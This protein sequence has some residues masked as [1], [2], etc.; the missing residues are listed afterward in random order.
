LYSYHD[1]SVLF[2]FKKIVP[3]G[4]DLLHIEHFTFTDTDN[5]PIF[6]Y[7]W[8]VEGSQTPRAIVQIA[9]GM[10][11]TAARYER[12]A[13]VLSVA[14]YEV[15]ANDHRGHGRTAGHP[16]QVG[17]IGEN[18]FSKMTDAMAQLTD[19]IAIRH[20]GIPIV[21]FGHSMGSFL[22]QQ[23]M[24]RYADKVSGVVL[25][26]TNGRHSSMIWVGIRI[27]E[28]LASTKGEEHRSKLLMKLSLGSY[29][30]A[31]QP[32]RTVCDWLSRDEAEVDRY[33]A[34]P[35]CGGVFT[36][37]FFRDFFRGLL[38]IH[39][40]KH[41]KRIPKQLPILLFAGERDPV[42]RMGKGVIQLLETYR[43]L[44]IGQVSCKLYPEG[45][46]EM[47]NETNR[48]EVTHD[49]IEWLNRTIT[50]IKN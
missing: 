44:G 7:H 22:A 39:Q 14:G 16:D 25:S 24:Y 35:F 41:M 30:K 49:I 9:H 2:I 38:D 4:C 5:K 36:A 10:A 15:Y 32:N 34:D 17:I 47:L 21:L 48:D 6:V 31:F 19:E 37:S 1:K 20:P 11:E 12:F 43:S 33:V 18:G 45:R 8:G 29:N 3:L 13:Q 26:G 50:A 28:L 23:Y 40:A 46:H 42:G 27:A